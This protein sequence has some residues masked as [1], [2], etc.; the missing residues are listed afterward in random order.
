MFSPEPSSGKKGRK[1]PVPKGP[2]VA[3]HDKGNNFSSLS[4][5]PIS[6]AAL[7]RGKKYIYSFSNLFGHIFMLIKRYSYN[8]FDTYS[9][10]I[11]DL[12]F[13]SKIRFYVMGII[14]FHFGFSF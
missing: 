14:D 5:R 12:T 7:R 10:K 6:A 3:N 1:L 2:G 4:T 9:R 8:N 13:S 11:D